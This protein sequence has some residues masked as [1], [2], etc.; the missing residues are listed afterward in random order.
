VDDSQRSAK[1]QIDLL[2]DEYRSLRDEARQRLSER[3][4]LLSFL[5][6]AAA[7]VIA[8]RN[9]VWGYVAGAASLTIAG[10]C[11]FGAGACWTSPGTMWRQSKRG[12][13]DRL[14]WPTAPSMMA[15]S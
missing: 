5:T 2:L 14:R 12:L 13:T 15:T 9:S 8:T 11:G 7:P 4:T 3:I 1:G 6:G 10:V